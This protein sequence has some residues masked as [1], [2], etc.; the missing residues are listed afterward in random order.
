MEVSQQNIQNLL[1]AYL[2]T[3]HRFEQRLIDENIPKIQTVISNFI[4]MKNGYSQWNLSNAINYN[5]FNILNINYRETTTHTPFLVN[6]LKT[7][8][9]HGQ[10]LLF[11]TAFIE[12]L[13]ISEDKKNRFTNINLNQIEVLEEK[14]TALYGRIDIF[15]QSIGLKQR[16]AVVIENKIDAP[17]QPK[18]LERYYNYCTK[19]L[20]LKDENILLVYLTKDGKTPSEYT[21][22]EDLKTRLV[23]VDVLKCLSYQTDISD[24]LNA[25]M[26]NVQSANVKEL[27]KQYIEIIKYF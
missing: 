13:K 1:E 26:P 24:M 23:D 21:I 18:Q 14:H 9:T 16:F 15:I 25:T 19:T 3:K 27:V 8:S 7:R 12:S 20:G 5:I 11:Y 10:Q 6:L 4:E 2:K 22:N 17:D